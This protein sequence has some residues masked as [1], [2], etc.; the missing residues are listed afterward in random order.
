MNLICEIN[1]FLHIYIIFYVYNI[2]V[3]MNF[4][5]FTQKYYKL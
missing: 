4:Y 1:K 5:F 2:S 3:Y